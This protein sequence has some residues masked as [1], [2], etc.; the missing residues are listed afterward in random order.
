MFHSKTG[1]QTKHTMRCPLTVKF[2]ER[3]VMTRMN[4]AINTH[5]KITR[6][7]YGPNTEMIYSKNTEEIQSYL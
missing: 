2:G 4:K 1:F 5:K 3:I 7:I 6:F